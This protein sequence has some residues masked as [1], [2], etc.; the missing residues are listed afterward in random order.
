MAAVDAEALV[1]IIVLGG[2]D[3]TSRIAYAGRE[4]AR[5]RELG[6]RAVLVLSSKGGLATDAQRERWRDMCVAK[7]GVPPEDYFEERR[8]G[9]TVENA[10][11]CLP[12]ALGSG[13]G[14][15]PGDW[16]HSAVAGSD[17]APPRPLLPTTLTVVTSTFHANR[18]GLLFRLAR[19]LVHG[20]YEVTT[21][22][23][24]DPVDP[25]RL[26][27]LPHATSARRSGA[28]EESVVALGLQGDPLA[29]EVLYEASQIGADVDMLRGRLAGAAG[30]G[31]GSASAVAI[32]E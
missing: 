23:V 21:I 28:L 27:A 9:T 5:L 22:A 31:H 14:L 25:V 2:P 32:A 29:C 24:P 30:P 10:L 17:G 12:H 3:V 18:A 4:Y 6:K 19:T 8:A 1:A 16:P 11:F 7:A 15:G 26:A 20:A 13:G